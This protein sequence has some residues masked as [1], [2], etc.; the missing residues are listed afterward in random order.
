M[1]PMQVPASASS[2]SLHHL[3]K[4]TEADEYYKVDWCDW[5]VSGCRKRIVF[6]S[7]Q[8]RRDGGERGTTG[9]ASVEV[10]S[11]KQTRNMICAAISPERAT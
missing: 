5:S 8:V 2:S 10:R 7:L 3:Q 9:N 1:A 4:E 6:F 11:A